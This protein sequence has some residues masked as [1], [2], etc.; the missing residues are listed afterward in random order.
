MTE[1]G[2]SQPNRG[3]VLNTDKATAVLVIPSNGEPHGVIQWHDTLVLS[4]ETFAQQKNITLTVVRTKGM[5]GGVIISYETVQALTVTQAN[6]VI[7]RPGADYITEKGVVRLGE[8]EDVANITI[9]V[10]HVCHT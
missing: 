8:G 3:A 1:T 9:D 2:S 7:A 6:E 4:Q 10:I 5:I